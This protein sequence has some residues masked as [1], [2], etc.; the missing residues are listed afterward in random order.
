[1]G[2][3]EIVLEHMFLREWVDAFI[4]ERFGD[5]SPDGDREPAGE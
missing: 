4:R 3:E 5:E 2:M 1:M